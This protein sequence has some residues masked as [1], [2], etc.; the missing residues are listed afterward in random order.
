MNSEDGFTR[1]EQT[2]LQD[3]EALRLRSTGLSYREIATQMCCDVST[4]RR[5]VSRALGEV[6]REL[7]DEYRTLEALRLDS[8]QEVI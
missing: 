4:A 3:I 6:S 8:L 2:L 1:S 5:R 7:A